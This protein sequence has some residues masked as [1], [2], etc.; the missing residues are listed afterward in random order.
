MKKNLLGE[1]VLEPWEQEIADRINNKVK[2]DLEKQIK[3]IF[4]SHN[5]KI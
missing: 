3:E 4:K 5:F 1:T 2:E